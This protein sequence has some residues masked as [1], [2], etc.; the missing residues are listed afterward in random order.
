MTTPRKDQR[1]LN[2]RER[3]IHYILSR[4]QSGDC[5]SVVGVGS[6]GKSNLLRHLL[7]KD[8]QHLHLGQEE[9][10]ALKTVLIDPNNMLDSLPLQLDPHQPS[11]WAGYE[12]LMHRLYK[13]F[14]PLTGLNDDDKKAFVLAYD[15]LHNGSNA[16]LPHISLRYLESA[17][18]KLFRQDNPVRRPQK[19]CFVFD[20]FEEMLTQL[21][22]K[23]FQA[24]RG[25]RDD[26]KYQLTYI[27]FTRRSLNH[28]VEESGGSKLALE[29]FVELFTDSTHY[30]GPYSDADATA[31]LDRLS[32]RQNVNFSPSFR[33]FLLKSTGGFAGL[34]RASFRLAAQIPFGTPEDKALQF[35]ADSPAIEAECRTIWE[36]LTQ[37]ERVMLIRIVTNQDSSESN[38]AVRLL[39]E[40][41][42]LKGQGVVEVN[43]SLFREFVR[44]I[45]AKGS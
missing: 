8:V 23:F 14:Y 13:S 29:P 43:P 39:L 40:K 34:L 22:A 38:S 20:E 24:L 27:T 21:P 3:D 31:M 18:E 42:L 6:V 33:R 17:L 2:F 9:A 1:N 12:I 26:Y 7:R 45:A 30:L 4:V 19:I 5:C 16:L 10:D 28:I 11:G 36:S 35:L 32:E 37:D 41:Q 15:Q 44:R 25:I